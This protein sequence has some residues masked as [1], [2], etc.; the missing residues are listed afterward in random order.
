[1]NEHGAELVTQR[2]GEVG[3]DLRGADAGM[4]QQDLDDAEINPLQEH[5][6]GKGVPERVRRKS[7]V[8]A[9]LVPRFLEGA[10]CALITEGSVAMTAS[11]D[12]HSVAF[13]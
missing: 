2:L 12:S 8:E 7:P 9:A 10:A 3:V 5:L 11:L 13:A 1:M 6:R 4:P